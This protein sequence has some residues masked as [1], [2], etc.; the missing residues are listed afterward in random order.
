M[1]FLPFGRSGLH[2]SN[3]AVGHNARMK[4][5]AALTAQNAGLKK[6]YFYTCMSEM[7]SGYDATV[8]RRFK[9]LLV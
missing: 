7:T 6:L 5:L 2:C 4:V 9:C 8:V 3:L 1:N